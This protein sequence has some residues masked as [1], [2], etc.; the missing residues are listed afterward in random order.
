MKAARLG[1]SFN[2]S[3]IKKQKNFSISTDLLTLYNSYHSKQS[4]G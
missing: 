3:T 4:K 1:T 2:V